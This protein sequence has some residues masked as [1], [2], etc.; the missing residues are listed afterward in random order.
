M[1]GYRFHHHSSSPHPPL[2]LSHLLAAVVL[3]DLRMCPIVRDAASF[4]PWCRRE[5][6]HV[7]DSCALR[8]AL[9]NF[10]LFPINY[11]FL[12]AGF[13]RSKKHQSHLVH[14]PYLTR[15]NCDR[16]R[17]STAGCQHSTWT[18]WS[19]SSHFNPATSSASGS[20]HLRIPNPLNGID[21]GN[22]LDIIIV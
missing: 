12:L 6:A 18:W 10:C 17:Q 13:R 2:P 15:W 14:L 4:E 21:D 19:R 9:Q 20:P 16:A 3:G 22:L 1:W 8:K 11:C 5:R 7:C